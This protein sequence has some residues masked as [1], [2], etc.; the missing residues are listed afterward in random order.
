MS[1]VFT[2]SSTDASPMMRLVT[3][4]VRDTPSDLCR[5]GRRRSVSMSRT[6]WPLCAMIE[7]R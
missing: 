7:P 2:Q 1:V 6:R 5:R 3:P 4:V